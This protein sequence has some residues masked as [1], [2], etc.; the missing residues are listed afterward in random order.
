MSLDHYVACEKYE[1][2]R[3][4]FKSASKT[5]TISKEINR[6]YFGVCTKR[7]FKFTLYVGNFTFDKHV[8]TAYVGVTQVIVVF[9]TY[10]F[11]SYDN[12]LFILVYGFQKKCMRS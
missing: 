7:H 12:C 10:L 4:T 8:H 2:H 6:R 3:G 1:R 9:R 11:A 5:I